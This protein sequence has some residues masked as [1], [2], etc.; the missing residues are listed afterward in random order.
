MWHSLSELT[1]MVADQTVTEAGTA[2]GSGPTTKNKNMPQ[3]SQPLAWGGL[4]EA[5][6]RE[7]EADSPLRLTE[8]MYN[9]SGGSGYE[10]IELQNIGDGDLDVS[11][12]YFD[13][14]IEFTFPPALPPLA[15]DEIVVIVSNPTVFAERYP[16]VPI[17][18]RYQ[19]Q[20]SNQGE[21]ISLRDKHGR[22][23]AA[24]QYDDENDWPLSPDGRGD[25]LRL[26]NKDGD[27]NEPSNW[28]AS[29]NLH[30]SP[31]LDGF[32]Q[33]ITEVEKR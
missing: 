7:V 10:F 2:H 3:S 1:N 13:E 24:V 32:P 28:R 4:V 5:A 16:G 30:G 17:A 31:G 6:S 9:P 12:M 15:P 8:I 23:L 25:S 33:A 19:G 11:K 21:R 14:G 29:T 27:A 20:L 26:L 18:G 22:L